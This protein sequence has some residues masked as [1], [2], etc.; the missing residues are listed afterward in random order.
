MWFFLHNPLFWVLMLV[1]LA[2]LW[3]RVSYLAELQ[4]NPSAQDRSPSLAE[5]LVMLVPGVCAFAA[6]V[7]F[8]SLLAGG[9][10]V[11]AYVLGFAGLVLYARRGSH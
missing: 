9:M 3:P 4:R 10:L 7:M 11:L 2:A 1:G 5:R 8:G 6:V